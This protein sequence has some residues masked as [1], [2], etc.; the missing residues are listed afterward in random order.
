MN[1]KRKLFLMK[2]W[3]ISG[4]LYLSLT[5]TQSIIKIKEKMNTNETFSFS[6]TSLNNI[7]NKIANLNINKPTT[8]NN[9]PAKIIRIYT[10]NL[11]LH[12]GR[13]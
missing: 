11:S 7:E 13:L 6:N 8:F 3:M 4:V 1:S 10:H 12:F 5:M 9:I 2:I